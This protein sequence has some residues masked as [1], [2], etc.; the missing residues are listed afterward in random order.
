[1]S[2]QAQRPPQHRWAG[3]GGASHAACLQPRLFAGVVGMAVVLIVDLIFAAYTH[4]LRCTLLPLPLLLLRAQAPGEAVDKYG[5]LGRGRI[6]RIL[7]DKMGRAG[8]GE[9]GGRAS[10]QRLRRL[11]CQCCA[12]LCCAPAFSPANVPPAGR[13]MRGAPR[14]GVPAASEWL[15]L[16]TVSVS[17]CVLPDGEDEQGAFFRG[18]LL[19]IAAAKL[20]RPAGTAGGQAAG[21]DVEEGD[22]EFEVAEEGEEEEESEKEEKAPKESAVAVA[23]VGW[24]WPPAVLAGWVGTVGAPLPHCAPTAVF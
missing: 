4:W 22:L 1:M 16:S 24:H 15:Q 2:R 19:R 21:D 14:R 12:V 7:A 6:L 20:D 17:V 13:R 23:T 8:V 3:C 5:D 18:R 9:V 10:C 11:L